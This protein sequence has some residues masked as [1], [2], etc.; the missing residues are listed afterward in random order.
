MDQVVEQ[1]VEGKEEVVE[2]SLSELGHV[3]GGLGV[4]NF[5]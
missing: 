5:G 4:D 3:G 2:L 1:V